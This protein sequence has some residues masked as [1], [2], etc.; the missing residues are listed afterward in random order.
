MAAIVIATMIVACVVLALALSF[1]SLPGS[2]SGESAESTATVSDVQT[3][4][5][6]TVSVLDV[7]QGQAVLVVTG[8]GS[9]ALID[10]G[11][12]QER[13]REEIEPYVRSLGVSS[14][15][16]L[17]LSHPDQDHVGGMPQVFESFDVGTWVDPGIPTTNQTYE[18]SVEIVLERNIPAI[19]ARKGEMLSLGPSTTLTLLWP[20]DDFILDG[21]EPDSNENSAVVLVTVGDIDILITGDLEDEERPTSSSKWELASNPK[22][23]SSDTM[24]VIHRARR[25]SSMPSTRKQRSS[26]SE[27]TT[28]MATRTTKSSSVS[29][30]GT[31]TSTGPTLMALLRFT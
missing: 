30:S 20:E 21:S 26:R 7:D 9:A 4:E 11:R 14:L 15:D 24:E 17:I 28:P 3:Y 29:V 25:G 5:E 22:F 10:A 27:R 23:W 31:S 12:S 6:T 1:V 13:I 2:D 19:L 18:E 8:D 16:Y